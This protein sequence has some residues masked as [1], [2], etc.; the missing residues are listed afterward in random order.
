MEPIL[1]YA[2][3]STPLGTLLAVASPNGLRALRFC[4]GAQLEQNLKELRRQSP[5]EALVED[6]DSLRPLL[7]QVQEVLAGR[8]PGDKVPLDPV[9]TPFQKRVWKTL[10]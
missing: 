8:L 9:G 2:R 5:K 3:R 7:D 4:E 10:A 6:A 1:R